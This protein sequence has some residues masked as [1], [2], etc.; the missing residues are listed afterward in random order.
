MPRRP[1]VAVLAPAE[2]R[3]VANSRELDTIHTMALFGLVFLFVAGVLIGVGIAVGL[4]GCAVAAALLGLGVVSSSFG[5]G[6]RSGRPAIGFRAFLLQ[7]G[8]LA[9]VPAGALCAWSGQALY[10]AYG[11]GWAVPV[12]GAVAGAITGLLV[13]LLLDCFT[14]RLH[15]WA[16]A[17]FISSSPDSRRATERNG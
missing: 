14:R 3:C 1:R 13:A 15:R 10:T 6:L 12:Y 11:S 8:I 4:V 5:I 7:C 9:G 17:R 2:W 16:S